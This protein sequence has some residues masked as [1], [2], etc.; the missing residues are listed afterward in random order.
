MFN[1]FFTKIESFLDN[2][3]KYGT[4]R[5]VKDA[6]IIRHMRSA[7]YINKAGHTLVVC[8]THCFST[9]IMVSRTRLNVTFTRTFSLSP[10][11][12][13][14]LSPNKTRTCGSEL[15]MKLMTLMLQVLLLAWAPS[16]V[17]GGDPVMPQQCYDIFLAHI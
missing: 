14:Q 5:Q 16:K 1:I 13:V 17:L 15:T 12:R 9:A 10:P 7:C 6:K 3:E 8:N 2:V 11:P 4:A